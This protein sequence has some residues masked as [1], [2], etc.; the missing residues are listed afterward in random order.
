[1]AEALRRIEKEYKRICELEDDLLEEKGII[2]VGPIDESDMFTWEAEI[3]G[4][5]ATPYES[6]IFVLNIK[7]PKEYPFKPPSIYFGTKIFHV[8]IHSD[9]KICCK[10]FPLLYTRWAPNI[11]IIEILTEIINLLKYP[12]FDSCLLYGYPYD[13]V[14]RCYN[15]RDYEYYNKIANEWTVKYAEGDYNEFFNHAGNITEYNNEITKLIINYENEL[16]KVNEFY[17]KLM[18]AIEENKNTINKE[19][20]KLKQLKQ[21]LIELSNSS[22][23]YYYF[24]KCKLKDLRD[25]LI[26]KDKEISELNLYIPLPIK[27]KLIT[28]TIISF[29]EKIHFTTTCLK[30]DYLSKIKELLYEKYPEYKNDHNIFYLKNNIVDE[31]NNLEKNGVKDNDI[32]MLKNSK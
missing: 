19:K 2:S 13:L 7:F 1:M 8:N 3:R 23:F 28:L 4:P 31:N 12:N 24:N 26:K 21:K 29:D 16:D 20:N 15:K 32:L 22:H 6:G 9:G 5:E 10:S 11:S 14:D 17:L 25:D 30:K 18:E 27:E